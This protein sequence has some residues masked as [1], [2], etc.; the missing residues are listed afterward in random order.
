MRRVVERGDTVWWYG[1]TPSISG[2]S[3]AILDNVYKTW[4]RGLGG[5]CAWLTVDPGTDPW[6]NCNGAATGSIYP[7][8][9]FGIPGPVPSI[10]LKIQRNG[11]QDIDLID[12]AAR[13]SGKLASVRER[14]ANS[15]P[16]AL[17]ETP[18]KAACEL[19]PE[20]WDNNNLS[21]EI[22]P[23]TLPPEAV[24]PMWWS[25]IRNTALNGKVC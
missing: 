17:W 7:G 15:L 12:D 16:I 14:I 2:A 18:P 25:S 20:D 8:E 1:G 9:R 11:I 19:P 23:G 24:D 6:F 21:T 13:N 5:F 10:R 22:E 3:S 4:A